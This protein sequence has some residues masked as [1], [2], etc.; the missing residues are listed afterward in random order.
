VCAENSSFGTKKKK[1][2][3]EHKQTYFGLG[4]R[5]F[6]TRVGLRASGKVRDF[7]LA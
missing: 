5:G 1:A 2:M 4:A 7:S 6:V 3:T